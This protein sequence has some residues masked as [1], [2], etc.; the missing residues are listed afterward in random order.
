MQRD[1]TQHESEMARTRTCREPGENDVAGFIS[2]PFGLRQIIYS[3]LLPSDGILYIPF[4][5]SEDENWAT[6]HALYTAHPFLA[7]E[8]RECMYR[9]CRPT[10]VIVP[11][12][13]SDLPHDLEWSRFR[14]IDIHMDYPKKRTS[15]P[16]DFCGMEQALRLLNKGAPAQLPDIKFRFVKAYDPDRR[17]ALHKRDGSLVQELLLPA[18]MRHWRRP[19]GP[20]YSILKQCWSILRRSTARSTPAFD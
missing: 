17:Y 13:E 19:Y 4:H 11:D 7:S 20:D 18:E 14:A 1:I 16:L 10:L 8:L 15:D 3:N 2:L 5:R 12:V 6:L 9:L